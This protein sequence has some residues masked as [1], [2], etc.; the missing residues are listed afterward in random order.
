LKP[1]LVYYK[2]GLGNRYGILKYV[3]KALKKQVKI[4]PLLIPKN[5]SDIILE[6]NFGLYQ[7]KECGIQQGLIRELQNLP[8]LLSH[9]LQVNTPTDTCSE[10]HTLLI[11]LYVWKT[12]AILHRSM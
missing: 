3:N 9:H 5:V 7:L 11:Y 10:L 12:V 2:E 1:I 4:L 6:R 8:L